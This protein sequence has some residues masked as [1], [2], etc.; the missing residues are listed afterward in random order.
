MRIRL[1]I[2]IVVSLLLNV[3]K[4]TIFAADPPPLAKA[5]LNTQRAQAFRQQW[6]K[7]NGKP[8]IYTNSIGMKLS[9]IPPG[10]FTMGRTE[11][12]FDKLIRRMKRDPEMKKHIDGT[13]VWSMLMMP[14]HRV[15]ITKPF[16][17][18][19]TEVTLGQFRQFAKATGYKTEAEQGL[20]YG[21]PYKG[22]RA[23]STW[24]K[25]MA[26]RKP[27]YRPKDNEPV[28]QLCYNDCMAFCK[29]LSKQQMVILIRK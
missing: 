10:E 1:L 21:R 23:L 7:H 20:V 15:R 17:M 6:A 2:T 26:W 25:P 28:L 5:P 11:E 12:E 3:V 22:R 27:P 24:R 19:S 9:F 14:A 13:L 29:W 8:T 18:G 16:Y 4:T